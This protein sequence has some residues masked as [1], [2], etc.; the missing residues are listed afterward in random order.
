MLIINILRFIF[1]YVSLYADGGFA[2]RFIN[3]CTSE[4]I[5]LW[6]IHKRNDRLYACTN[7]NGYKRIR[8]PARKSGMK[9]RMIKKHGIPFFLFKHRMRRGLL[10]GFIIFF[11]ALMFLSD[12]IWIIQVEGNVNVSE[13]VIENAFEEAGLTIG[14]R[15][16]SLKLI[17]I[18]S[19][20]LSEL[21]DITWASINITGCTA[22]IEV[23]EG[24][25]SPKMEETGGT[26][27]IVASKDGQVQI[28]EPYRGTSAVKPGQTV[29]EGDLLVSGV[30][31][32]RTQ[33]YLFSDANG[34][35]AATT[36]IETGAE[37]SYTQKALIPETKKRYSLYFLGKEFPPDVSKGKE[38][39]YLHKKLMCIKGKKL[40]FGIFYRVYTAY[41]E[42]DRTLSK[43]EAKLIALNAYALKSYNDTLHVQIISQNVSLKQT[44]TQVSITGEYSCYENIGKRVA[45]EVEETPQSDVQEKDTVN[46]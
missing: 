24:T 13:T 41:S 14:S 44:D 34:Y 21:N 5:P 15:T 25:K 7:V 20:A 8:A 36:S 3:V 2:E 18:K 19:D 33:S 26:S 23:R 22:V 30:T 45:F 46:N 29:T 42:E 12:H 9:V 28:I 10:I 43:A 1:G 17:E 31:E 38:N 27:N 35:I 40:P 32:S 39:C 6:N 11:I 37:V 4:G 16:S